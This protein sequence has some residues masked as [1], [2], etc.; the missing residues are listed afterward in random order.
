MTEHMSSRTS[1]N[2][3]S[4]ADR[5]RSALADSSVGTS[6]LFSNLDDLGVIDRIDVQNKIATI[7]IVLPVASETFQSRI[8]EEITSIATDIDDISDIVVRWDP[9]APDPE[10]RVEMLPD[11]KNIIAVASGKGG[12]GKSTVATNF[13]VALADA[14][15]NVGL[16]DADIYGPNTPK[17]LGLNERSPDATLDSRIIPREAHGVKVMS[18]GFI[19]GEDDPVIWRGPI[20]DD[21]LKQLFGDVEWGELDYLFV[22]LPPGTGDTQLSLVQN[23]PVTGAVIV[24]TPSSIAI[25]D[26]RRG[27]KQFIKYDVPL[28]GIVENMSEFICPD[29]QSVSDIFGTGGGETLAEEFDLPLI[30][31]LPLDSAVGM[32]DTDETDP[33]GFTIPRIGRVQL[34]RTREERESHKTKPPVSVQN[35]DSDVRRGLRE[36]ASRVAAQAALLATK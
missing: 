17:M 2:V 28:L 15:A 8:E 23:L 32:M 21:M 22:D 7:S 33:L 13:A 1:S 30:A 9:S 35:V 29:C 34:P 14:G 19:V 5:L 18:M 31:Q 25:D 16:L 4:P 11:V 36:G 24:T 26:A 6:V 10:I 3:N 12:V 20:V 27:L